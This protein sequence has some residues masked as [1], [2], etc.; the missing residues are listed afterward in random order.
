MQNIGFGVRRWG[1]DPGL[2]LTS[3]AA[4][5]ESVSLSKAQCSLYWNESNNNGYFGT[6]IS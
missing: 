2:Y 6:Q 1:L 4:M 3:Q 5:S